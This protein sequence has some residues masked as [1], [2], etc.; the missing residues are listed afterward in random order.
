MVRLRRRGEAILARFADGTIKNTQ[1]LTPV[2]ERRRR[3]RLR[4]STLMRMPFQ[5]AMRDEAAGRLGPQF[6]QVL[7][8]NGPNCRSITSIASRMDSSAKDRPTTCT[9]IGAEPAL[10][11]VPTPPAGSPNTGIAMFGH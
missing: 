3:T 7:T 9:P 6:D 11:W 1:V 2:T 10:M 5:R 4:C 8:P